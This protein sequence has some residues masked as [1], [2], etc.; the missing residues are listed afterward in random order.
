MTNDQETFNCEH[1]D[2]RFQHRVLEMTREIGRMHYRSPSAIDQLEVRAAE[3]IAEF[4]SAECME[5]T[6]DEVMAGQGISIP[7]NRPDVLPIERCSMCAG[8]VDMSDWH[9]TFTEGE[10]EFAGATLC[11]IDVQYVAVVCGGCAPNGELRAA[12]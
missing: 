10:S 1:C 12:I 11:P 4:C 7:T 2:S 6:R 9:L 5:A 3:T 8:P